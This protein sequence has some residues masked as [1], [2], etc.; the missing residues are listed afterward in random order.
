MAIY[1]ILAFCVEVVLLVTP[2]YIWDKP[3][4]VV[5]ANILLVVLTAP[6]QIDVNEQGK[7]SLKLLVE[8][9]EIA[10]VTKPH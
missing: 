1:W 7:F 9:A 5:Y 4:S 2:P 6:L 10:K 8:F 3:I